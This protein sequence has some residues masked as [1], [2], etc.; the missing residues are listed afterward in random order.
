[1]AALRKATR[2]TLASSV[3]AGLLMDSLQLLLQNR[4]N[5]LA[6]GG[7]LADGRWCLGLVELDRRLAFS[8]PLAVDGGCGD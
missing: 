3:L 4:G 1:M 5:K 8:W 2:Q 7:W 6:V